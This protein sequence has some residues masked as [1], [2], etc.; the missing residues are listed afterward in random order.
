[1]KKL[2]SASNSQIKNSNLA[3]YEDYI[4]LKFNYAYLLI[5]CKYFVQ[6]KLQFKFYS[7]LIFIKKQKV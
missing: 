6:I 7:L 2:W 3:N 1:M 4:N 5:I